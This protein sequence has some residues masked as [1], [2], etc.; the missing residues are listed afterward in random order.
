MITEEGTSY[1]VTS[2]TKY[3]QRSATSRKSE[4]NKNSGI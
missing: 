4:G 2:V 1:S 3:Q